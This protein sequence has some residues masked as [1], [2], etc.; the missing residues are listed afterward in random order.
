MHRQ[1]NLALYPGQKSRNFFQFVEFQ[2]VM[3]F[4]ENLQELIRYAVL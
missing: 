3:L 2:D 4:A 1:K